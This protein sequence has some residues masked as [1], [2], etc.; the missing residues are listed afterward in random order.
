[1]PAIEAV[2]RDRR[3]HSPRQVYLFHGSSG[4]PSPLMH[5]E[6]ADMWVAVLRLDHRLEV[7]EDTRPLGTSYSGHSEDIVYYAAVDNCMLAAA[8]SICGMQA[9]ATPSSFAVEHGG[10][11][12]QRRAEDRQRGRRR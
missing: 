6:A 4:L 1:M 12:P 5:Q 3:F 10:N 2:P 11:R 8:P 9:M 7:A